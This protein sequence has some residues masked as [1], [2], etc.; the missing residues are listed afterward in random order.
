[1][2][3][4]GLVCNYYIVNYGSAL[5]CFAT[6]K[7]IKEMGYDVEAIQFANI[8]TKEAKMQL[9]LRLK[10]K[11]F[12]NPK[13]IMLKLRRMKNGSSNQKYIDI[14]EKRRD[15][16]NIFI[17]E[18]LKMSKKYSDISEVSKD[19]ANYDVIVLGSDQLLNPKDIIF[20]YHTLSFVPDDIKKI[21]YA[22]SFGLSKLP[23]TVR[24]KAAKELD[25][26]D[27]FAARESRGV[28]IYKELTGKDVPLVVDPT[29]LL[30]ASEWSSIVGVDPIIQDKYIYCYFIGENPEHRE[31]ARRLQK[32][33]GYKIAII[34]HIDEFIKEDEEFGDIVLNEAGP[35]DFVNIV[36]NAE[37]VLAD[38]FHATIFSIINHKKFY[39]LNRFAEGSS[40]STNSRLDS[41]LG[42]LKLEN[43]RIG[44]VEDIEKT[45]M[46]E[47]DYDKVDSILKPWIEE[48]KNYLKNALEN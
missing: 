44:S 39:V 17:S 3:K 12:F 11:Q 46:A 6:E 36:S 24:A 25:R 13:A 33:T 27:C 2:K 22:A 47:I 8:P 16:F 31:I 26:F 18:N 7:T 28:E 40:G 4:I 45:Y 35:K 19:C 41:L 15:K 10:L 5:Q 42:K 43:R 1:M 14:R 20:G 48:S 29:L 23:V 38:S 32:I 37:Y 34:R 30:D 21:S 9:F